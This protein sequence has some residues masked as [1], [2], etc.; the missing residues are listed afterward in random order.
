MFLNFALTL[1]VS[2]FTAPPPEE[3]QRMVGEIRL[4]GEAA[5]P[6]H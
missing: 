1:I 5:S 6:S 3:V 4:P 2:R